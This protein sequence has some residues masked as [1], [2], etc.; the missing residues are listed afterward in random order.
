MSTQETPARIGDLPALGRPANR[1][2]LSIGVTTL[3]QA[4]QLTE[5][6]LLALHGVGPRA[7][8]LLDEAF[9]EQGLDFRTSRY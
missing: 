6:E 8:R 1:A 4:S 9:A 5:A 7:I 2:L 3:A